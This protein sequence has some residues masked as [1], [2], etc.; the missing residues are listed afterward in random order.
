MDGYEVAVFTSPAAVEG[1]G[2]RW[3]RHPPA[4]S[5]SWHLIQNERPVTWCGIDFSYAF[6][7]RRLW[8]KTPE[9]QRCHI[10]VGRLERVSLTNPSRWMAAEGEGTGGHP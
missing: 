2:R 1:V 3:R 6:S 5:S 8:S 9:D 10:C 7:P 4:S